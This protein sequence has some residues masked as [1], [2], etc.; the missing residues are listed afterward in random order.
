MEFNLSL[1]CD[2]GS[3]KQLQSVFLSSDPAGPVKRS[4]I[5][6]QITDATWKETFRE[7]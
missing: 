4:W 7:T 2:K 6:I 1:P 3:L 5:A